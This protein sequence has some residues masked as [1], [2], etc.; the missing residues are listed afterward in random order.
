[1][2][3]QLPICQLTDQTD[4]TGWMDRWTNMIEEKGRPDKNSQALEDPANPIPVRFLMRHPVT[5]LD[6]A[7]RAEM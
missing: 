4:K 2:I 5:I 3:C 1:M 6:E 7:T